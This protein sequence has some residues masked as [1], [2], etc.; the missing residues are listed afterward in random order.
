MVGGRDAAQLA[1]W[2]AEAE[3]MALQPLTRMLLSYV[4]AIHV[5]AAGF[6]VFRYI[7]KRI[8]LSLMLAYLSL[9]PAVFALR[10]FQ[11]ISVQIG[12]SLLWVSAI[13]GTFLLAFIWDAHVRRP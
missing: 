5:M 7:R 11:I 12:W 8:P 6:F 10:E 2:R 3:A 9:G 4:I 13:L 1:R